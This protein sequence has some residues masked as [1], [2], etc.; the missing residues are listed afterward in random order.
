MA[1]PVVG[2]SSTADISGVLGENTVGGSVT[3]PVVSAGVLGVGSSKAGVVGTSNAN[4]G[5]W[6]S[7]TESDG[8]LGAS[9][10]TT[11]IGVHGVNFSGNGSA[12]SYPEAAYGVLGLSAGGPGVSGISQNDY[13][14]RGATSNGQAAVLGESDLAVG[15]QGSSTTANGVRGM[16]VNS[17]GIVGTSQGQDA[18]GVLGA[19]DAATGIGVLGTSQGGIGIQAESSGVNHALVAYAKTS[20]ANTAAGVYAESATGYGVLGQGGYAGVRGSSDVI[21]VLGTSTNGQG[22]EAASVNNY[23]LYAE[24]LGPKHAIWAYAKTSQPNTAAGILAESTAGYGVIGNGVWGVQGVGADIGVTGSCAN[25]IGVSGS[26]ANGQ[27]IVG[28]SESPTY[29]AIFGNGHLATGIY[30]T[31]NNPAY[32]GVQ[33]DGGILARQ[34]NSVYPALDV[35][36]S[37]GHGIKAST[38]NGTYSA[39]YAENTTGAWAGYF[40]GNVGVTGTITAPAGALVIDHPQDPENRY[41]THA[42]VASPEMLTIYSG[43]VTTDDSGEAAVAL[44]PYFEAL[45][46]DFRYQLTVQGTFAQAIISD[47]INQN[48]FTIRTDKPD[49]HVYWQVTGVRRD[50]FAQSLPM[51]VEVDKSTSTVRR[52]EAGARIRE[53][54]PPDL[55]DSVR[56]PP[57][58]PSEADSA[59]SPGRRVERELRELADGSVRRAGRDGG[60]RR[61]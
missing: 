22:M 2:I 1:G 50:S 47:E 20:Q 14:V 4:V 3:P 36:G 12:P 19:N 39:V 25:G 5:V 27:G 17:H 32:S 15:V 31:S 23:G 11:G 48:Q 46:M 42:F 57:A 18:A 7:S 9:D 54:S 6:G 38:E 41:L 52:P 30:G 56:H 16:S 44:P 58:I 40:L 60:Q 33:S 24:S 34:L 21:G 37:G 55:P 43:S 51:P 35:R 8:V 49:V 45:N 13:G 28:Y 53:V 61:E 26:S 29:P 59:T 10:A